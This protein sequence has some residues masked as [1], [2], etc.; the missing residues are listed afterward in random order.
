MISQAI[1]NGGK[2]GDFVFS[3]KAELVAQM[4]VR[5]NPARWVCAGWARGQRSLRRLA[6]VQGRR[7]ADATVP[8]VCSR[9]SSKQNRWMPCGR[10][11]ASGRWSPALTWCI[12]PRGEAG[13]VLPRA[14]VCPVG[15]L[16][17]LCAGTR[18]GHAQQPGSHGRRLAAL[19]LGSAGLCRKRAAEQSQGHRA[20]G[21]AKLTSAPRLKILER[22]TALTQIQRAPCLPLVPPSTAPGQQESTLK[23]PLLPYT[24]TG[25]L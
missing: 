25:P 12:L 17:E 24:G 13:A 10:R 4:V 23:S 7:G 5:A 20:L 19:G 16:A 8:L 21:C 3:R 6:R 22:V 11:F 15:R 18:R 14:A 2:C 1:Y 9:S